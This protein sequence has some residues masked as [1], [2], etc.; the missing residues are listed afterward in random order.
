VLL[1]HG[2]LA[3]RPPFT[4]LAQVRDQDVGEHDLD[5]DGAEQAIQHRMRP[6]RVE[7]VEGRD[8]T[9][10]EFLD[11]RLLLCGFTRPGVDPRREAGCFGGGETVSDQ[12]SRPPH[13]RFVISG[14]EPEAARRARGAQQVVALFPGPKQFRRNAGAA[15]E[16][17]DP[18][19]RV[20]VCTLHN[21]DDIYTNS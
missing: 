11:Q 12:S 10:S 8:Q 5:R 14:V 18:H 13:P 2:D 21:F 4:E 19:H 9:G 16:L 17:A 1:G 15:G 20:H 3:Y 7:T 6:G